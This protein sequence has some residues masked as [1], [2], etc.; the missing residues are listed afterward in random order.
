MILR[1]VQL[2]LLLFLFSCNISR[3]ESGHEA[4]QD[5]YKCQTDTLINILNSFDSA[6]TDNGIKRDSLQQLFLQ[7]RF[8][9]KLV[10]PIIEYYFQGHVKRINGP[11]LPD[12]KTDDNQ[13]FP[14]HGFQVIEQFLWSES[15]LNDSLRAK[16]QSEVR[17][18]LADLRF[19]KINFKEQT[20][21]ARHVR[22]MV[23]HELIRIA[24][25]SIVGLDAPMSFASLDEA[26]YAL[27]GSAFLIEKYMDG[28]VRKKSS[29]YPLFIPSIKYLLSNNDFD[30]FNRLEFIKSF[31]IPLS[32]DL[33]S[34]II[35]EDK[36][37]QQIRS[38]FKGNLADLMVGK[39]FSPDF[40]SP[41]ASG[42][43]NPAKVM[44]GKTLFYDKRLS[45]NN[46]ISCASCHKP[47]LFFSDG[48][49]IAPN[50]VHG[51]K[52]F[53]NTPTLLYAGLQAAQFYDLRTSSLEEQIHAVF[54]SK[55][56]FNSS[57]EKIV[58]E[59]NATIQYRELSKK[60]FGTD[61]IGY[62]EIRNAIA[63]YVR[64][65]NAFSSDFDNYMRGDTLALRKEARVGFNLFMGKAKCGTCHFAPVFNGTLPP[66]FTKSESE[67]IGVPET[68]IWTDG[69]I[70]PDKGRFM[71]NQLDELKYAFKTPTV[72]NIS[73]TGPY[74]HNGVYTKLCDVVEFY[75]RGG[76]SGIGINLPHQ[77]LPF[78]SLRL[79][80][81]EKQ[82]LISFM[83]SLTDK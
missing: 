41:Y 32:K 40:Y 83:E 42:E 25:A 60:A 26:V 81:V 2:L 16:L 62:F 66:W 79:T 68:A 57:P 7:A 77:S 39:G 47:E 36:D 9:Y 54:S 43:M 48:L 49:K 74:M 76:G 12:I 58:K 55:G 27:K 46:K 65:L 33:S 30:T 8:R 19:T 29:I 11:A 72:R 37:D 69:K 10:E 38:A 51:G 61:T 18:L 15:L 52:L 78:D 63:S 31:L 23:Q 6:S 17:I 70:D 24:T 5:Y 67:I 71:L 50:L 1:I 80:S 75:H 20:V 21:L 82:A 45:A 14:P 73:K 34:I 22:E 3:V 53:R 13:V 64:S 59:M 4:V 56:E 28:V 35:E 44:L